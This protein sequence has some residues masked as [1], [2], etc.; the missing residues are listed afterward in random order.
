[1]CFCNYLMS[2]LP[3]LKINYGPEDFFKYVLICQTLKL[4]ECTLFLMIA[5]PLHVCACL[6]HLRVQCEGLNLEYVS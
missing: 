2:Y 4:I 5:H 6:Q 1:M 3:N